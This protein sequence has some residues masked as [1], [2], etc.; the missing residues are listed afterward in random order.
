MHLETRRL[1]LRPFQDGDATA[2][3]AC[4]HDLDVARFMY[5]VPHPFTIQHASDFV[6]RVT[7]K[8][9]QV[10][11]VTCQS[12]LVG[13]VGTAGAFGYWIGR[14]HR[15]RGIATEAANAALSYYFSAPQNNKISASHMDENLSSGRLLHKLGFQ[16]TGRTMLHSTV[17]DAPVPGNRLTLERKYWVDHHGPL[18]G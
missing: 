11:A 8:A 16:V 9:G 5:S 10:W 14:P 18:A 1:M 13:M 12:E 4:C 17:R 6:L 15:Q 7:P 3:Q 2:V